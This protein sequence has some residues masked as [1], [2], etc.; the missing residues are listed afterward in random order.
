MQNYNHLLIIVIGLPTFLRHQGCSWLCW[1]AFKPLWVS[2]ILQFLNCHP[3]FLLVFV[4]M[5][6]SI[7]FGDYN[8]VDTLNKKWLDG[9]YFLGDLIIYESLEIFLANKNALSRVGPKRNW[10]MFLIWLGSMWH[11]NIIII[12]IFP[13]IICILPF[14]SFLQL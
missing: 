1:N 9:S 7:A 4:V 12:I 3:P 10:Q 2:R 13:V 8:T 11:E 14:P 5:I 6:I